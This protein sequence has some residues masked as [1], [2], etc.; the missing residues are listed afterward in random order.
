[1]IQ[2]AI[3]VYRTLGRSGDCGHGQIRAFHPLSDTSLWG[4]DAIF[5]G[6]PALRLRTALGSKLDVNCSCQADA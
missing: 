3:S 4:S 2:I 5:L 1:M 6:G